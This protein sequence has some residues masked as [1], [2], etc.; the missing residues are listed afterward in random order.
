MQPIIEFKD[1]TKSFGEKKIL[2]RFSFTV[3]EGEIFCL[4]GGSGTGKSVTLK[5][6]LGLM[7]FDDGE[8]CFQGKSISKMNLKEINEMRTHV[9]M[10]FQGSALFDSLSVYENIAYPLRE[11]GGYTEGEIAKVV[12]EKLDLVAL[13]GI[14]DL[15]PADLSGGMRK[16]VGLARAIAVNPQVVLYDEPTAG[17]DPTNT[18]RIDDLILRLANDYK[19]TSVLVT[20]HMPSVYKIATNVAL[21][22]E[23]RVAFQ[24]SIAEFRQTR[25]PIV[26]KFVEGKIGE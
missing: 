22:Y 3:G 1:V 17:L 4:I 18:N 5:L 9:G 7:E 20:H 19:V 14:E 6:L 13:P 10:V 8:V 11:R 23:K 24:G 25:D 16:R 26:Q 2:D 21:L 12:A 15:E